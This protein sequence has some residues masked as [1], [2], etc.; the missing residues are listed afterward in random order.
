[1]DVC[2]I[3]A[4]LITRSHWAGPPH[5]SA[6]KN[7]SPTMAGRIKSFFT[8]RNHGTVIIVFAQ[9]RTPQQNG[10]RPSRR[11]ANSPIELTITS[12][13]SNLTERPHRRRT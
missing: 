6:N 11:H 7:N 3:G 4:N 12:G 10:R 8:R 1:V 5:F 13:Q 2:R 9:W